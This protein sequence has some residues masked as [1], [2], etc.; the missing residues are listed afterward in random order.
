MC[1]ADLRHTP[2]PELHAAM[3]TRRLPAE[4]QLHTFN[5]IPGNQLSTSL[6]TFVFVQRQLQA[7]AGFTET[8]SHRPRARD[9]SLH[10]S[11]FHYIQ[12][13][14]TCP[15]LVC[16][17]R[18]EGQACS[19]ACSHVCT[20]QAG[21]GSVLLQSFKKKK[22]HSVDTQ[23]VTLLVSTQSFHSKACCRCQLAGAAPFI[24]VPAVV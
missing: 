22:P 20:M 23:L 6:Q 1:P 3:H 15:T 14:S 13:A 24:A 21:S 5:H 19:V 12:V 10:S 18:P 7:A 8:R 9:D 4:A 11:A 2:P 16:D 17:T